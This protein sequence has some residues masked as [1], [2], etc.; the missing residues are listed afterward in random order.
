M[1]RR[2]G[3]KGAQRSGARAL[4]RRLLDQDS[5]E[6]RFRRGY[7]AFDLSGARKPTLRSFPCFSISVPISIRA[8]QSATKATTTRPIA[9]VARE[10]GIALVTPYTSNAKDP[11]AYFPKLLYRA[12]AR[13]EQ[14]VG[15]LKR[16]KRVALRCEKT[17]KNFLAL[18]QRSAGFILLQSVQTA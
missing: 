2:R 3:Q 9:R 13:I 15:K 8:P 5:S 1:S 17:A 12:R 14:A 18:V 11:P 10:R 4:A 6:D 16:F 7:L